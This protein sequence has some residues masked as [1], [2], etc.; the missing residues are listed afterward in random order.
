MQSAQEV[1][2]GG[3]VVTVD[4]S[5]ESVSS[6]DNAK[7]VVMSSSRNRECRVP[8][9]TNSRDANS[10]HHSGDPHS[11]M[12]IG[13]KYLL[14]DLVD[15][16]SFYKCVNVATNEEYACKIVSR[17]NYS[18]VSAHYRLETHPR[19]ASL[20]EILVGNQYLYLIFPKFQGDLHS[21]VRNRKRLRESEAK[22]LF[23]QIAE[24]VQV[25]HQN[26]I[27][28]RDLKLRKFIFA[29]SQRTEL[30]LESLEDAV[31]LEEPESDWL[32]DKRG[33]PA[34]V[35]P[36]I[37]KAGATYS[38]KA[39][40]MWSLGVILYTMLAGRYPFNDMEHSLLFAKISRGHFTIPECLS[41]RAR[42]LIRSLL[43]RDPSERITSED[44][45]FHPWLAKEERDWTSRSCD[46]Q[47]PECSMFD[48]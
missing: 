21:Y 2:E 45:L 9:V 24:T 8:R 15:G 11:P 48:D 13:D 33:C 18:L 37:L 35:S 47:V 46:Q 6:S 19:I 38:G 16:S 32:H 30:K 3:R 39:A 1:M 31:V 7:N 25:C 17:D 22:K 42:C 43:R 28:L 12:I 41:S 40:D 14:M 34:Y 36:E 44:I 26:G 23:K 10:G 29:D 4:K 5:V 27:V 20:H